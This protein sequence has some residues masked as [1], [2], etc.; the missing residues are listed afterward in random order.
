MGHQDLPLVSVITP[1]FNQSAFIRKTIESVLSQDYPNIEHIVVD[2][3]S[4]D[5][6]LEIL[7]EYAHLG[8][9]LRYISEPDRGQS[10]AINKGLAMANGQ[11]I[12]WLNSDDKYMPGAVAKAINAL[13]AHPH[14]AMVYGNA[15]HINA[16]DKIT[17]VY[18]TKPFSRQALF[19]F[20]IICQPSA[21]VRKEVFQAVGGVDENLHY[22]MDYDLW[23][24]I[25]KSYAVGHIQD[26]LAASRLHPACKS[27]ALE[28][29]LGLPEIL[30]ASVRH[31]GTVANHWLYHFLTHYPDKGVFWYLDLFKSH[32]VFG[33]TPILVDSNRHSSYWVPP[34]YRLHLHVDPAEPMHA[35]V[36]KGVNLLFN[37]PVHVHV[38]V[39]Q[40]PVA[41]HVIPAGPFE[42]SIPFPVKEP[43]SVVEL[44]CSR[45]QALPE[46]EMAASIGT[47]S[48]QVQNVAPL[49]AQEYQFYLQYKKNPRDVAGW[50]LKNRNPVP[51]L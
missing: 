29:D 13:T 5:G 12:G 46:N 49:S 36:I 23:M 42:T 37:Q 11:I 35:L 41:H 9:R 10:H 30:L 14:W 47:V 32:R 27:I 4:T 26:F 31:F 28:V 34:R 24:R 38:M 43:N 25:S 2:G 6:T 20:C 16:E 33:D 51:S 19:L 17:S 7:R 48:F 3:G 18:P 22:C 8:D 44:V 40:T 15:L 45:Q 1:S 39:N 21:F 50:L